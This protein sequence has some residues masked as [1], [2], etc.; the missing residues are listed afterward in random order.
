[1]LERAEAADAATRPQRERAARSHQRLWGC[2]V[3]GL[4]SDA[5]PAKAPLCSAFAARF[6]GAPPERCPFE[7]VF[8]GDP[9]VVR[10]GEAAELLEAG[11]SE[12]VAWKGE[13]TAVDRDALLITL[14]ARNRCNALSVKSK[15][16]QPRE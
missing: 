4:T 1:M 7:G 9:L 11:S 3:A 14:R 2:R 10:V 12:R 13:P 15:D 5:T 16:P 8:A 6:G